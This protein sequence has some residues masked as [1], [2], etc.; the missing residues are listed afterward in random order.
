[1]TPARR[2]ALALALAAGCNSFDPSYDEPKCGTQGECPDGLF[3]ILGTCGPQSCGDGVIVGTEL[4]DDGNLNESDGCDAT[5]TAAT[6]FVPV[7]HPTVAAGLA[8]PACPT[9]Y[10][11]SGTYEERVTVSRDVAVVGVG[12]E[13]VV[14]DGAA[15]GT[16]ITVDAGV[17]ATLRGLA[18]RNGQAPAGGGIVNRGTLTLDAVTVSDN[19][20]V[21]PAPAGGGIDNAGTLTLTASVVTRNHLI[22]T[23]TSSPMMTILLSGAGIRSTAGVVRLEKASLV[24]ANE[25]IVTGLP[26]AAGQGAGIQAQ[27]TSLLVSEASAVRNNILDIDGHP[28][29]AS[30]SGA[31]LSLSGGTFKLETG[32]A[33]E[34]NVATAKGVDPSYGG[35]SAT[36]GGFYASSTLITMNGAFVRSNQAIALSEGRATAT[37]GGGLLYGGSLAVTDAEINSNTARAESLGTDS[38]AYASAITGG[39]QLSD[40]L[41]VSITDSQLSSNIVSASTASTTTGGSAQVGA[42]RVTSSDPQMITLVHCTIDGNMVTSPNGSAV[43]GALQVDLHTGSG[44]VLNVNIAQTTI[45]NNLASGLSA[46]AGAL[47]ATVSTGTAQVLN[48]SFVQTTISNN[49]ASGV[50]SAEAGAVLADAGTG[51]TTVNLNFVNSTISGNRVEA[52]MGAARSGAIQGTTGTGSAK[53]NVNLASA[54]ITENRATG[55][56]AQWGGLSLETGISTSMTT[57]SLKNSIVAGNLAP[58]D[59]DCRSSGAPITSG[60][61]NLIGNLGSCTLSG[62][63]TGNRSGAAGLGPLADN[64]G[65]TLTHALLSG[66]QAIDAGNPAGCTDLAGTVLATDQR[67]QVRGF[68]CDIGAFE[69]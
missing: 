17:T 3:C 8:D 4:C 68:R 36:G 34:N 23:A 26:L 63:L 46:R 7:T 53:V 1:M 52:P 6:C 35:A 15:R 31:G 58:V 5:C 64:G 48:V 19:V 54:T 2:I 69:R 25:I 32:G 14:L 12:A 38:N 51:D 33:V 30:A 57:A 65:P 21:A 13:P 9:V 47:S 10:V 56:T 43:S 59:P 55:M 16:V 24:E 29:A 66:S 11:Y 28:G 61:Y 20:A 41:S 39:L 27:N 44:D 62:N 22:S 60:G 50:S 18:I 49:V 45:N 37:A 67:G 40:T 42:L